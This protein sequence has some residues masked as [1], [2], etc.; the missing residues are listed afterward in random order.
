MADLKSM[1]EAERSAFYKSEIQ[2]AAGAGLT[3]TQGSGKPFSD[4]TSDN[5]SNVAPGH[6]VRQ[7][8]DTAR[9]IY[10]EAQKHAS[11]IENILTPTEI[12]QANAFGR[13]AAYKDA[14]AKGIKPDGNMVSLAGEAAVRAAAAAK[15]AK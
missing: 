14:A 8:A 7:T 15:G 4:G 10:Q 2:R 5:R 11:K 6:G 9:H 12:V 3:N 13:Q 1:S